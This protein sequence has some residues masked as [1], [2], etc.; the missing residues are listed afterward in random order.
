MSLEELSS[1][2]EEAMHVW[3]ADRDASCRT[4]RRAGKR[5]RDA[6]RVRSR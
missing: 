4:D 3:D 2:S 5:Q 1:D 6:V